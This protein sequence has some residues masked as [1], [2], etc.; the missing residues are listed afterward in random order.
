MRGLSSGFLTPNLGPSFHI[1][2]F[3]QLHPVL[4]FV[5]VVMLTI[6]SLT[7]LWHFLRTWYSEL[8]ALPSIQWGSLTHD[9]QLAKWYLKLLYKIMK[10]IRREKQQQCGKQTLSYNEQVEVKSSKVRKDEREERNRGKAN[11]FPM[12]ESC[13]HIL[14]AYVT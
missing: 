1:M 11:T 10:L 12:Q 3:G 6:K 2:F 9:S 8:T 13:P 5:L 7:V 4:P 14:C